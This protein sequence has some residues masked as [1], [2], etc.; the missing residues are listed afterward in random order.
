[1]SDFK[2]YK[3]LL[4]EINQ[5]C[6]DKR[7]GTVFITTDDE[8]LVRFVLQEGEIISLAFDASHNNYDAINQVQ[9]IKRGK[10]Q[11]AENIFDQASEVPLPTTAALL[12]NL[13]TIPTASMTSREVVIEQIV[14]LLAEYIGPFAQ[15]SCDDYLDEQGTPT[16]K[17][18]FEKMLETIATEIDDETERKAFQRQA[19]Q[20]I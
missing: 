10:V 6:A 9:M 18:A 13:A 19:L 14:A 4:N 1:M 15:F 17:V 7:T 12:S 3:F 16:D 20:L 11:F 5:L 8:H 2:S